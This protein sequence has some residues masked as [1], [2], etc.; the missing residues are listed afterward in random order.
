MGAMLEDAL[1][2]GAK[3]EVGGEVRETDHFFHPTIL[4]KVPAQ[5][6]LL[7]E[8]IFGPILPI[9][10]YSSLQ[11]AI[12]FVNSKPK[13]LALYIYSQ[14]ERQQKEIINT[15]SSGA[16]CINE[17]AVHFLNNHLPFGGVNNSGLG[18]THGQYGFQA[19]SHLKPVM[20]QRNGLTSV[21]PLYP[22]YTKVGKQLMN[23]LLKMF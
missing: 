4:T 10:T 23:W 7:E 6:R 11:E 13:P 21:K 19:F 8:E 1:A 2:K 3:L 18:S 5:A 16:V 14:R 20:K 17:S 15:T 9:V 12:A 22:P